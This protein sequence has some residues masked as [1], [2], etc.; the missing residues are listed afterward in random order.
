MVPWWFEPSNRAIS[1][2]EQAGVPTQLNHERNSDQG[3][4]ISLKW[5][6][7]DADIPI[8]SMSILDNLSAT[9]HLAIEK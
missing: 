4:F 1:L 6:D 3:V 5:I 8:V 7:P 9:Q 2:H